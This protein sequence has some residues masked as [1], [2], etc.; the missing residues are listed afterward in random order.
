MIDDTIVT[1]VKDADFNSG[2]VSAFLESREMAGNGPNMLYSQWDN[3]KYIDS[4]GTLHDFTN[5]S[6]LQAAPYVLSLAH[7][8]GFAAGYQYTGRSRSAGGA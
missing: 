1:A 5:T 3:L 2:F 4:Q 7:D 8:T 6:Y